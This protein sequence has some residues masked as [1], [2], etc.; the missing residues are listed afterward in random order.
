[1]LSVYMLALVQGLAVPGSSE[2]LLL[3]VAILA[4]I[5]I[6]SLCKVPLLYIDGYNLLGNF[7]GMD[8]LL[9]FF[10]LLWVGVDRL[11]MDTQWT[12]HR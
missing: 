6:L 8:G 2:S 11:S 7:S 5:I 12:R 9:I 4:G 3:L 10:C 1:M